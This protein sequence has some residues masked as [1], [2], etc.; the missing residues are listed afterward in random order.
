MLL[1]KQRIVIHLF[2]AILPAVS[3]ASSTRCAREKAASRQSASCES[4]SCEV[5]RAESPLAVADFVGDDD[6]IYVARC[7]HA[8]DERERVE[9]FSVL[10]A[11]HRDR[12]LNL[13]WQMLGSRD[14]AEDA[15]QEAFTLAFRSLPSF[16]NEAR[17]GTWIYRI[18]INVCLGRKRAAK[19]CESFDD[20]DVALHGDANHDA[21]KRAEKRLHV[22]RTLDAMSSNLRAVLVLREIHDLSYEEIARVLSVPVGTVRSRLSEARRKFIALWEAE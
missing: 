17:F 14:D 21:A 5:A 13:A 10:L 8:A 18:A 12:V 2:L 7:V 11:R 20:V 1:K 19:S 22:A 16:R 6:A 4:A 9:A 15:A 3:R